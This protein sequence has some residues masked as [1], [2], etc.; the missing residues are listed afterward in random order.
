[1]LTVRNLAG[2]EDSVV[3][4]QQSTQYQSLVE[5]I[6]FL[7]KASIVFALVIAAGAIAHKFKQYRLRASSQTEPLSEKAMRKQFETA[8]REG[9]SG[10]AI[11]LFY[12]WLDNYGGKD[13][14]GS[15]RER[16]V[17]IDQVKLKKAF[18]KIMRS[19]YTQE[20]SEIDLKLFANQFIKELRKPDRRRVLERSQ[21]EFQLNG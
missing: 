7:K 1:M 12:R 4:E 11:G 8:C 2:I 20:H 21:V 15:I 16:L 10:S 14:K 13:F 6:P 18:T 5:L 3:E 17:E 9:N 19:I